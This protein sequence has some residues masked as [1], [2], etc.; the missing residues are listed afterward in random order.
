MKPADIL[1]LNKPPI[2]LIFGDAGTGK[3]ALVSQ[4]KNSYLMDFDNGMLTAA[5][6]KD[7][8]YDL[9][10]KIE[11]DIFV[12]PN[13]RKPIMYH[14]S[15]QTLSHIST[16]CQL[17][18]WEYD[19][20]IIDSMTGVAKTIMLTTMFEAEGDSTQKPERNHWG[21]MVSYMEAFMSYLRLLKNKLVIITAHTNS[22]E[23]DKGQLLKTFPSSITKNYGLKS[24]PWMV[25]ELW[26][27]SIRPEG[28]GTFGF[29][30]DGSHKDKLITRTRSNFGLVRH[31]IIGLEGV[32]EKVGYRMSEE[33]TVK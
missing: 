19:S 11:F 22:D 8:F 9:R 13:P 21:G 17:N 28:A 12:E 20:L 33:S 14:K 31:D 24:L 32:L 5:N 26:Q 6:L 15:L 2:I 27:A 25:D 30:V 23:N 4:A 29:Y 16:K 3:T 1:K 18:T 10:Q 7:K